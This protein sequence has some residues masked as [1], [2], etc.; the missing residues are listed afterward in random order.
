MK[1]QDNPTSHRVQTAGQARPKDRTVQANPVTDRRAIYCVFA[2]CFAVRPV[3][4]VGAR[5]RDLSRGS[6]SFYA[7]SVKE[8]G[9]GS[10][11]SHAH[12]T[13]HTLCFLEGKEP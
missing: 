8:P 12:R 11:D 3:G 7:G 5:G 9:A 2:S 6:S 1:N 4:T 13:D 10:G